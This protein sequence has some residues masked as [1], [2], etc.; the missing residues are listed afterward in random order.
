MPVMLEPVPP[1]LQGEGALE[2]LGAHAVR[3]AGEGSAVL[4]VADPQGPRTSKLGQS[5]SSC[6]ERFLG[7]AV[8]D[9]VVLDPSHAAGV[10]APLLQLLRAQ[11][12]HEPHPA[13]VATAVPAAAATH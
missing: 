11:L 5:L 4:L 8:H 6:A 1:M 2:D 3:L 9:A 7:A 13:S 10:S 12:A